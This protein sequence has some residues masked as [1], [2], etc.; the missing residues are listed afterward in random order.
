MGKLTIK[1]FIK[2]CTG[3]LKSGSDSARPEDLPEILNQ[4]NSFRKVSSIILNTPGE[5][6]HPFEEQALDLLKSEVTR[7]I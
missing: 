6:I 3:R 1:S 5:T 2:R 7:G 4:S